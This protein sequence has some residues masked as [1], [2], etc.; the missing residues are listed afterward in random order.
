MANKK[1]QKQQKPAT[2]RNREE[3]R[4]NTRNPRSQSAGKPMWLRIV[5]LAILA[6]MFLGFFLLPLIR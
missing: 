5:I 6:V 4:L 2:G 1:T 3:K